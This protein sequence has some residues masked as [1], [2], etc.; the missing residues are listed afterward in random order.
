MPMAVSLIGLKKPKNIMVGSGLDK[1]R[2]QQEATH[3]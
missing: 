2:E 3:E 1:R